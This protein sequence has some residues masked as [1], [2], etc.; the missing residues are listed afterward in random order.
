MSAV[1]TDQQ[2]SLFLQFRE[3]RPHQDQDHSG[4]CFADS[5]DDFNIDDF[6]CRIDN[7]EAELSQDGPLDGGH[8]LGRGHT[9]D[10]DDAREAKHFWDTEKEVLS[11]ANLLETLDNSD[12]TV[13][14]GSGFIC[15]ESDDEATRKLIGQDP[16]LGSLVLLYG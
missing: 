2:R 7:I 11:S 12:E 6:R 14:L 16:S 15:E 5:D 8:P 9:L 13:D 1:G 3:D 10:L 4:L